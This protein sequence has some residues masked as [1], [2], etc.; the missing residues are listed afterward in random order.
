M[1]KRANR[2]MGKQEKREKGK[3]ENRETGKQENRKTGEQANGRMGKMEENGQTGKTGDGRRETGDGRRE[4]G[5][6]R[7]ETGD[8]RRE[9]G[10]GRRETGDGRRGEWENQ[11][12]CQIKYTK[13]RKWANRQKGDGR[14]E[15]LGN[16]KM[17]IIFSYSNDAA[18]GQGATKKREALLLASCAEGTTGGGLVEFELTAL[19][20]LGTREQSN[21]RVCL[22]HTTL[23]KAHNR[24]ASFATFIGPP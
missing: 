12:M 19:T 9:T 2:K 4:T 18:R 11:I 10:D 17:N 15:Q 22:W 6:G 8:G 23:T 20:S 16:R 1:E 3:Q 13:Y 5:D 24:E 7:R 21:Y 14:Q